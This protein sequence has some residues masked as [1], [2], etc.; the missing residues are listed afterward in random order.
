MATDQISDGARLLARGA[1]V[2]LKDGAHRVIFDYEALEFLEEE[3]EGIENFIELAREA[4]WKAR[5]LRTVRLGLTAGLLHERP[6]EVPLEEFRR[7]LGKLIDIGDLFLYLNAI[8]TAIFE[9]LPAA[10]EGEDDPKA[11]GGASSPGKRSTTSR[12][13]RSAA[14]TANSGG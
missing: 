4:K 8:D 9:S 2:T 3:F 6:S 13:S 10:E 14:A 5:R 11:K 1:T 12:R 7:H